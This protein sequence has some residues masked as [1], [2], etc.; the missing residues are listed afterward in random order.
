MENRGNITKIDK[1][2]LNKVSNV[3][4]FKGFRFI[5]PAPIVSLVNSAYGTSTSSVEQSPSK[6]IVKFGKQTR[7]KP[8]VKGDT[9]KTRESRKLQ[10]LGVDRRMVPFL[11]DCHMKCRDKTTS[12]DRQLIWNEFRSITDITSR[13]QYL[14]GLIQIRTPVRQRF[15]SKRKKNRHKT[16]VFSLKLTGSEDDSD[17]K[18]C[19]SCFMLVFNVTRG[20]I[21]TIIQK[22]VENGQSNEIVMQQGCHAPGNKIKL[23]HIE[24]CQIFLL[25][26]PQYESHYGRK[27][28]DKLYL[29]SHHT[30]S[31][32]F[33][34]FK[35]TFSENRVNFEKFCKILTGLNLSIK[36]KAIDTCKSC[37]EFA[38][39]MKVDT[40]EEEKS[41][42]RAAQQE[43]WVKWQHA[44][45]SKKYD[46]NRARLDQS[47]R[48]VAYDLEQNLPT[49]N[50]STSVAY[51][52]RL[53]YTYNLTV[54]DL[55]S[56]ESVHHMWH[57]GM[58]K[59]GS[60]EI[61]S[62]VYNYGITLPPIV[63]HFIKYSDR[64]P[65]QNLNMFTIVADLLLLQ[66]SPSLEII[67]SK[68]L[69]SGHTHMEVDQCHA[70][71][72]KRKKKIDE[73]I[74]IPDD[75][76]KMVDKASPKFTVQKMNQMNFMNF[77]D[78]LKKELVYRKK[79]IQNTPWTFQNIVWFRVVKD[80]PGVFFYKNSYD[81]NEVFKEVNL[82]RGKNQKDVKFNAQLLLQEDYIPIQSE[83][84]QDLL[85]LLKF[86]KPENR[87]FYQNLIVE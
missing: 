68:F 12:D 74:E 82:I 41:K 50:L 39:L 4:E 1:K 64:C 35:Q 55:V 87:D 84:K 46:A 44:V 70:L 69:V 37:D 21:A 20:K 5:N 43:H 29:P 3:F 47:I 36:C 22:K 75:W 62:C 23:D 28:S 59:R 78:V 38:I 49:P 24:Q 85:N 45:E 57:E 31:S 66:N 25:S 40:N 30:K 52:S 61:N 15:N 65:G 80:K 34:D 73:P 11:P 60:N 10:N 53:L 83:K 76:Y 27:D 18:L 81:E 8:S 19:K 13:A 42:I 51:Y 16:I 63:K 48:V 26:V 79:N 54:Y 72:E 71:I 58:S 14:A 2:L 86:I 56:T 9:K 17:W 33:Q 77:S 32:L 6:T 67:D 7:H